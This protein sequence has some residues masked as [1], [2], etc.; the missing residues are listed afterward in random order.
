M[1]KFCKIAMLIT[2]KYFEIDKLK[3]ECGETL[4]PITLAFET[5]GELNSQK[6][7][8]ILLF[9]ALTGDA[10]AAGKH[11]SSDTKTGWYDKFIGPNKAL[12]TNKYFIICSNI[13]GGCAGSTGPSSIN[14]L[15]NKPYGLN[16]P[17]ITIK[18]MIKGQYK[19]VESFGIEKLHACIGGS[20]GAMQALEWMITYPESSNSCIIMASAPYQSP[21]NIAL[22]EVGRR[23]IMN[24][25]NWNKGNYYDS[26]EKPNNGLSIARMIAHIS[27][28]S[29][30]SMHLKFGRKIQ[31]KEELNFEL[32]NEFEVESY[33]NYQGKAFIKRFDANSYLYITRAVDYFDYSGDKLQKAL[34]KNSCKY[35]IISFSSDWLYPEYQSIQIVNALQS[36]NL[37]VFYNRIESVYGHDAFLLEDEKLTPVL[38]GFLEHI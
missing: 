6:N 7:N 14:K 24:D 8:A 33:L 29:D 1:L 16:F 21:Q 2:T 4:S 27:Y 11:N 18:D 10:H 32:H 38:Q 31:G 3:L 20:L 19:L 12:D 34:N 25:I 26:I 17:F 5:Y 37:S 30:Q 13:L 23:A 28:L 22:H 9:H 36:L 15:T 35:L